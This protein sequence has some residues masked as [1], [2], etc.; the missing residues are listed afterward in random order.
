MS[1]HAIRLRGP[2][3]VT[4]HGD[5]RRR[6][7]AWPI[8][9]GEVLTPDY[10]GLVILSRHFNKPRIDRHESLWLVCSD[11]EVPMDACLN[12]SILGNI[13]R[14]DRVEF[15]IGDRC[16]PPVDEINLSF[17]IGPERP[18]AKGDVRL[19]IRHSQ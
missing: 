2:W 3:E 5:G 13:P 19:E 6:R 7:A 1:V 15:H 10:T 11:F 17:E 12:A 9:L 8:A 18:T 4:S 14:Q 16:L